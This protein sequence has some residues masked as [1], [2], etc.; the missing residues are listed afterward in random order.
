VSRPAPRPKPQGPSVEPGQVYFEWKY[1]V[2]GT[3]IGPARNKSR[4][5]LNEGIN[6]TSELSFFYN[7]PIW[8]SRRFEQLAVGR[9][10]DNP[11]VDPERNSLQRF[12]TRITGPTFEAT[13]GDSLVNYSRLTLNQNV[14]GLHAWK[15]LPHKLRLF[16][17]AGFF[18]DRWGSLYRDFSAFR[19]LADPVL[20]PEIP[21][22]PYSRLVGGA[23]LERKIGPSGWVGVNWTH[24]EDQLQTL[25]EAF[26]VCE[27][28]ATGIRTLVRLSA[29]CG[30]SVE[31]PGA[32]RPAP[33]AI[34]NDVVGIDTDLEL[35]RL[36]LRFRG[37]FVSSWTA[38]GT[39]P[40]AANFNNFLCA[41]QPPIVGASVLDARCFGGQ[42]QDFAG[43]FEVTQRVR[44]WNWRI[45]Y[46]RFQPD[47]FSANARQIRDLQ[48]LSLRTE[49]QF[50]K[51]VIIA[52]AFRRSNDNLN[53]KR[54]FINIVRAPEVRMIFRD[55][56]PYKRV[57]VEIGYRER[58][59][60]T[61]GDPRVTCSAAGVQTMRSAKLG[62][63]A[64][65][66]FVS[67][68]QRVR[69]TRIPFLSA[70]MRLGTAQFSFDYEHRSDR[71]AVRPALSSDTDRFAFG[72]R[73]TYS[74]G[75]WDVSPS[76]R[77]ELE[78]LGKN[79]PF[80]PLR[81][82]V[83]PALVFPIDFFDAFDTN[84]SFQAGLFVEA[85]RYV[86]FESEYREFNSLILS[87]LRASAM[88]DP[89][90]STF[91]LNQGFKRPNWRS[92]ATYKINNDENR[93]VTAFFERTSNFFNPGDPFIED[94]KSF[95]ETV[96]GGLIIIRFGR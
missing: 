67:T 48:D 12:Y 6:H 40:S 32:R 60:D 55:L 89:Q 86:R 17:T 73:G 61:G 36:N 5:F 41:S 47:F 64:S 82:P 19:N 68:E 21:G 80:D 75:G 69:S 15:D 81:S 96:I 58:N 14:K 13:L 49:Y 8:G 52:A 90:L 57:T 45:D 91:Y 62:C 7:T 66:T 2:D 79:T 4:S 9:Y 72:Y 22:K 78:R 37:E 29:G 84:R 83:D 93:T 1:R 53:G 70:G 31:I 20:N 23:R 50:P 88:L 76:F 42:E 10:T 71:D 74:W 33:E 26:T 87:P 51:P 46:S 54:N 63:Q 65:E 16:G 11:R 35:P 44:Q 92:S 38:G 43:R 3:Q 77:F 59:L 18:T 34:N 27:D 25:P 94:Q 28:V 56:P 30:T 39:P 24:G 85:P 95:R